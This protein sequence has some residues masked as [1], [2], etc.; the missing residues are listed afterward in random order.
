LIL[1]CCGG[2]FGWLVAELAASFI[3]KKIIFFFNYGIVGYRFDAQLPPPPT[4]LIPLQQLTRLQLRKKTQLNEWFSNTLKGEWSR[5]EVGQPSTQ[6]I[7]NCPL[8]QIKDLI[9][10]PAVHSTS[11]HSI[12]PK[13][14]K[15][16][17]SFH[18]FLFV[19]LVE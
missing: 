5:N 11:F 14:R 2:V 13:K 1:F 18:C 7:T 9:E 15:I 19:S 16:N 12:Q 17:L 4:N 3:K 10:G 6:P 8:I